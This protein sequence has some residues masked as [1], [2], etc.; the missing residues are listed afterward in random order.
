MGRPLVFDSPIQGQGLGSD[1]T[2]ITYHYD[3]LYRLTSADYFTST[4]GAEP[5]VMSFAYTYDRVGNRQTFTQTMGLSQTVHT[6]GYDEADRLTIVDGQTYTWDNN[7]NLTIDGTRAYTY[8]A[9]NRLTLVN[10]GGVSASYTYNGDG[11]L[12]NQTV[13]GVSTTFTWDVA[14]ALPQVLATS[15]GA[16]E[17]RYVY[18]LGLLAQQQGGAWQYPL[19]DGLGSIRR[20]TDPQGYLLAQQYSF[21][22][23]GVPLSQ[24]GGGQPFG[25][26][27]EQWDANTSLIYLRARWYNPALGRFMTRDPFPGMAALPGTQNPY[28]YGL[29]NPANLTDPS[30]RIAPLVAAGVGAV[31]GGTAAGVQ[32]VMAHPGQRP[33]DYLQDAGFQQ[34]VG[35]GALSGGVAGAVGFFAAGVAFGGGF[36]GAMASGIFS[37][38]LTGVA[39]QVTTNLAMGCPWHRGA[40]EA[41]VTGGLIG[42]ITGGAGYG[43]GRLLS[44]GAVA[45]A[46]EE[47]TTA[48]RVVRS[49]NGRL[50][51]PAHQATMTAIRRDIELRGLVSDTEFFV[52]TPGGIKNTRFVDVVALDPNNGLQPVE[53][54]QVGRLKA[55]GFPVAREMRA[56]LDILQHGNHPGVPLWFH[57]Y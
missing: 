13:G 9:A 42:G 55:N 25:Y 1:A 28:A 41:G 19:V 51:G 11:L 23:F 6:Y 54:H 2:V 7:G 33:E 49:P 17:A 12:A 36:G 22:P 46:T 26:A 43:I 29:N 10:G 4:S 8:D 52:R 40:L 16:N 44:P 38:A 31:I 37:G 48:A 45:T 18:G 32:Y 35:V 47:S 57:E 50:G 14:A 21:D 27:G 53:F 39:G 15:S 20:L 3:D 34:A 5:P 24:D 30:G 56:I